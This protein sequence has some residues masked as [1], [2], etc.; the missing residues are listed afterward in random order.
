MGLMKHW[1]TLGLLAAFSTGC[2]TLRGDKQKVKFETEPTGAILTVGDRTFT[3]PCEVT[4]KR[5]ENP[6]CTVQ[7]EGYQ[8][9][10]FTMKARWD[11][12]SLTDLAVPGG[13]ILMGLSLV[14]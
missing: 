6:S 9:I 3:T 11:G 13:S 2:A 10:M 12:A 8:T 5:K 7:K 4:I 1:I 14:T